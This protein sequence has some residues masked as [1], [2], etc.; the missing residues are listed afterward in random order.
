MEVIKDILED[1]SCR[2]P[3]LEWKIC[4]LTTFS[5]QMLPPGLFISR[6]GLTAKDCIHEIKS[7]LKALALQS[8]EPRASYIAKRVQ[9]KINVLVTVC[10]IQ[11]HKTKPDEKRQFGIEVISTR[12]Q[13]IQSL[14][15]DISTL[16]TQQQ[17][18]MKTVEHMR[19]STNVHGMLSVQTEL[20]EIEKRLT[21]ATETLK[22]AING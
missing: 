18:M 2:L 12:Q 16:F 20:G 10:Q 8:N 14:E 21:I 9:R 22:Q 4:R 11:G 6:V 17:A 1:L 15:K 19:C 7:D 3:E 13:W 5:A